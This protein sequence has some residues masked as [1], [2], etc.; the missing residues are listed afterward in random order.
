[1]ACINL[2]LD[3]SCTA[4]LN[5]DMIL[6][7]GRYGCYNNY[8]IRVTDYNNVPH[9]LTFSYDDVG[10]CFKV[11]IIDPRSGNSCWG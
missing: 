1:M 5:A 9:P 7:G 6:E 8:I 4:V 11:T 3:T 2:S 10:H